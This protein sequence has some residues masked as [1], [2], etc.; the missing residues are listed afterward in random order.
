MTLGKGLDSG[1]KGT[2]FR[3]GRETRVGKGRIIIRIHY[4]HV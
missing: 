4:I 1:E 2:V 3:D